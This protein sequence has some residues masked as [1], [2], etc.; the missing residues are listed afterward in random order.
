M[1]RRAIVHSAHAGQ[2][3]RPEEGLGGAVT[4][5]FAKDVLQGEPSGCNR[6]AKDNT[7]EDNERN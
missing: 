7:E 3:R 1:N 2:K 4:V 6:D 5:E